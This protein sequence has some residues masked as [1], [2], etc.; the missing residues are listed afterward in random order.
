MAV[1]NLLIDGIGGVVQLNNVET[2]K[3]IFF[4]KKKLAKIDVLVYIISVNSVSK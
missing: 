4:L 2:H 1:K 3:K